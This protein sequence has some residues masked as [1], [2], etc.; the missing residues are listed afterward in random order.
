MCLL[1]FYQW[2]NK[3]TNILLESYQKMRSA[4]LACDIYP[5]PT[6]FKKQIKYAQQRNIEYVV[7]VGSD[8][9]EKDML[10]VKHMPS[11]EQYARS[12]EEILKGNYKKA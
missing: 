2:M 7:I 1:S 11:G 3:R 5:E 10:T 12:K 6:K 8:E 9:M 4:N